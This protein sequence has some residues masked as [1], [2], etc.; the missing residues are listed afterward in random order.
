MYTATAPQCKD[1]SPSRC[2]EA[3]ITTEREGEREKGALI[4]VSF[5]PF[6]A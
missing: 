6:S 5:P 1:I 2:W 4:E 3:T